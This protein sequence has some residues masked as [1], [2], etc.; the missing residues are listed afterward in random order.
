M[1]EDKFIILKEGDFEYRLLFPPFPPDYD[2]WTK[3]QAKE[4]LDWFVSHFD[5]QA[6]YV[7]NKS[8]E[9]FGINPNTI[10]TSDEKLLLVWRWFLKYARKEPVPEEEKDEMW[11]YYKSI[12][13]MMA[14]EYRLSPVTLIFARDIGMLMAKLWLEDVKNLQWEVGYPTAKKN[15]FHNHP[16]LSG[17][18]FT[19]E[20]YDNPG[21][22]K[23]Y[24]SCCDPVHIAETQ[25]VR[26]LR[27]A[28]KETDLVRIYNVWR[29]GDYNYNI[30]SL[31]LR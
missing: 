9:E 22:T 14:N 11:Y 2:N 31:N 5:E 10:K 28:Q 30:T 7:L 25:G 6:D 12:G 24:E 19:D 1:Q 29:F 21:T 27:N 23:Q 15:Y 20:D 3:K 17:F 8:Y 18:I 4:Y 13:S 16:M 26:I